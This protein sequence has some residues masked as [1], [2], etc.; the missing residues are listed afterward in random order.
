M[1]VLSVPMT[2]VETPGFVREA[3]AALTGD[4]RIEVIS[5]VAA[6]LE[7]GGSMPETGGARKLRWRSQGR[8]KRGGARVTYYYRN[9]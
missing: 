8:G 9:L 7:A 5:F 1:N 3:A 4:E 6:N 2:V